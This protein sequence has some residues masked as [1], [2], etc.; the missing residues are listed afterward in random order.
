MSPP[1]TPTF[2][3]GCLTFTGEGN[4]MI[5]VHTYYLYHKHTSFVLTYFVW[6]SKSPFAC[7]LQEWEVLTTLA[8]RSVAKYDCCPEEYPDVTFQFFLQR[9]SPF[10]RWFEAEMHTVFY[11]VTLSSSFQSS[12]PVLGNLKIKL[13]NLWKRYWRPQSYFCIISNVGLN[14]YFERENIGA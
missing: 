10:F 7:C 14:L 11:S 13:L 12:L 6:F 2:R 8:T 1:P 4:I 9:R 3:R 5:D